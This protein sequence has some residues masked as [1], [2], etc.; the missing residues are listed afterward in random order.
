MSTPPQG[1]VLEYRGGVPQARDGCTE[2]LLPFTL[3][4]RSGYKFLEF[5][6]DGQL[7]GDG[8]FYVRSGGDRVPDGIFTL[9]TLDGKPFGQHGYRDGN[10]EG[11]IVTWYPNGLVQWRGSFA[12][13]KRSGRWEVFHDT[14]Q[15]DEME[16]GIY[17]NDIKVEPLN[18]K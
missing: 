2:L 4:E 18:G 13:N 10:V 5:N 12:N 3:N 6:R 14:G 17:V 11:P 15:L 16:S 1:V 7:I 9:L 8:F